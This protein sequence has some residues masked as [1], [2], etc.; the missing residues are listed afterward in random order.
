[1]RLVQDHIIPRLALEHM[2]IPARERVRCY[3]HVEVVL[4]VPPLSQLLAPLGVPVVAQDFE[5]RQEL[6]ELHLP[7]EQY[8]SGHDDEMRT[9]DPTIAGEMCKQ[10]NRLNCFSASKSNP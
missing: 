10:G 1:M 4:V 7:V 2:R 3:A 6:F 5:A 8:A 9:P